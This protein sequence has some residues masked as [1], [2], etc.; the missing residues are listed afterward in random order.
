MSPPTFLQTLA[1][2]VARMQSLHPER[3]GELAR[4]HALILHGQVLPSP[5]DPTTGQVLSSDGVTHYTVNGRCDCQAGQHGKPCKHVQ[6]WKLYQ[7]IERRVASQMPQDERAAPGETRDTSGG[8]AG[9]P[10]ARASLNLKVLVQ[11]FETQITLRDHDEAAL[12]GRLQ[13]LLKRPD[14]HPIPKPAPRSGHWNGRQ[15]QG[16]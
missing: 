1:A 13:A 8:P 9:L 12:L 4:A 16:R 2:E 10:E 6:V 11:G 3:E 15:S 7:Y 5:E 14:V